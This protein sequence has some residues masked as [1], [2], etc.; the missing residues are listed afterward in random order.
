MHIL[1]VG[2]GGVVGQKLAHSL[3]KR[4][5]L[6][7][8]EISKITLA[9]IVD[10]PKVIAPLMWPASVATLAILPQLRIR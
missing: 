5:K 7:G 6:R 8:Q 2:G 10:P 4:G 9:D 3:V 1:I